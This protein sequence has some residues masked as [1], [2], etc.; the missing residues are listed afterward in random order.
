MQQNCWGNMRNLLTNIELIGRI[1]L[2]LCSF[3]FSLVISSCGNNMDNKTN[4]DYLGNSSY[5]IVSP[6]DSPAI[7]MNNI[8]N[9]VIL[10][11]LT[12]DDVFQDDEKLWKIF[13]ATNF[14]KTYPFTAEYN[15]LL[16]EHFPESIDNPKGSNVPWESRLN[17]EIAKYYKPTN[18]TPL[19][20]MVRIRMTN[21]SGLNLFFTDIENVFGKKWSIYKEFVIREPFNPAPLP[22]KSPYAYKKIVYKL[23]TKTN[24]M[25]VD[26]IMR[27]DNLGYLENLEIEILGR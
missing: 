23:E 27:F 6:P 13:G 5:P 1:R 14:F 4:S 15:S 12:K 3:F 9:A 8:K 18:P 25:P 10:G 24:S 19:N 21:M 26:T 2:L 17:V 20:F 7:L 22:A 16:L 11:L